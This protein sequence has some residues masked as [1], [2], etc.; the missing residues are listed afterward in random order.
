MNG[1]CPYQEH[2]PASHEEQALFLLVNEHSSQ[3]RIAPTGHIVGFDQLALLAIAKTRGLD[4]S[5]LAELLPYAEHGMLE[6]LQS[7]RTD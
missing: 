3:L 7:Q 4:D 1:L 2:A 6:A 5:V